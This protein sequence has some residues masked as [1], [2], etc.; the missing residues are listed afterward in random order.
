MV[1]GPQELAELAWILVNEAVQR[2]TITVP[3]T[4]RPVAVEDDAYIRL[5]QWAAGQKIRSKRAPVVKPEDFGL[6]KTKETRP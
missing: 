3:A 2:K 5:L 4:Q 1:L 6:K